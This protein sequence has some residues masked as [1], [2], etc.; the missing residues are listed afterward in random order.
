V[1][2]GAVSTFANLLLA[3]ACI[4]NITQHKPS[5]DSGMCVS[6]RADGCG[7]GG[8]LTSAR[9]RTKSLRRIGE[10]SACATPQFGHI[11]ARGSY[12]RFSESGARSGMPGAVTQCIGKQN[13]RSAAWLYAPFDV[14][15]VRGGKSMDSSSSHTLLPEMIASKIIERDCSIPRIP[16]RFGQPVS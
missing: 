14:G 3:Q 15:Q 13:E 4:R 8:S 16:M 12:E 2:Y 1:R 6:V 5:I 9:S 10:A 7:D 11:N